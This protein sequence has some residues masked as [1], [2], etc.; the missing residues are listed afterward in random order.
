MSATELNLPLFFLEILMHKEQGCFESS[1]QHSLSYLCEEMS[2]SEGYTWMELGMLRGWGE[3]EYHKA[4]GELWN[5]YETMW[6]I[7][8]MQM[9][10]E[11]EM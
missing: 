8:E 11:L 3:L 10:L 6:C 4:L 2:N 7:F 5:I 1:F 9:S